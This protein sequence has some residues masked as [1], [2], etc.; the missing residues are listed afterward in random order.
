M[1]TY[2]LWIEIEEHDDETEEYRNTTKEGD[3]GAE[4]VAIGNF[5]DLASA[6]R[7]AES[8]E[9]HFDKGDPIIPVEMIPKQNDETAHF[10][11]S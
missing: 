7:A 8:L 2:K 6:I 1:K 11:S 4:P 10:R 5:D 9:F 3:G